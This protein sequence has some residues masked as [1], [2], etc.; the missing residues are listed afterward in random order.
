MKIESIQSELPNWY[1]PQAPGYTKPKSFEGCR[2][3]IHIP[4]GVNPTKELADARVRLQPRYPGATLHLVPEY[5]KSSGPAQSFNVTG[6]DEELLRAYFSSITLPTHVTIDQIISYISKFIPAISVFGSKGMKFKSVI[7]DNVLCFEHCEIDLDLTG[8]TLVT[9]LNKD[10]NNHSNGSG[11]SSYTSLPFIAL[12]GKTFKDQSQDEWAS[13]FN[14]KNARISLEVI[15]SDGR[16]LEVIRQRRPGALRAFLDGNEVTMGTVP[17]T[18]NLI[19]RLTNLTWEVLTN[20]LYI[21]Q[22]EI[23]SVFGT[24]KDRKELFSRLLGLERFLDAQAK[25]S[26]ISLR[27]KRSA[28]LIDTDIDMTD[29]RMQECMGTIAELKISLKNLPQVSEKETSRLTL[30][31]NNVKSKVDAKEKELQELGLSRESLL[32]ETREWTS[33]ISEARTQIKSFQKTL[34]DSKDA[35]ERCHVCGNKIDPKILNRFQNEL[36]T[37]IVSESEQLVKFTNKETNLISKI[38]FIRTKER[39]LSEEINKLKNTRHQLATSIQVRTLQ[40]DEQ[41][42]LL[43][44]VETYQLRIKELEKNKLIHEQAKRFTLEEKQFVDLCVNAVSRNGLPAYLC[45]TV[46][47]QLNQT[48]QHYSEVFADGEIGIQFAASNGDVDVDVRNLHGGKQTKDQSAGEMR[49]AAIVTAFTFR[50]VL[51]QL[52]LLI[53]DEPSEGF[54]PANSLAFAKGLNQVLDRFAHVMV[55]S[56][57]TNL[58][59]ALEPDRRIEIVKEDGVSTASIVSL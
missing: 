59:S 6:S 28:E 10:W 38:T 12:F 5:T 2:V 52:N 36:Q 34:E 7:A 37:A 24:E 20:A 29:A 8:L 19:E 17:A 58:L 42:R 21:G 32:V 16:K 27:I 50:D 4:V 46:T 31:L 13:Q 33:K 57:N 22:S 48:A 25:L 53:I 51:L 40:I 26:K 44:K 49:M 23:G 11:K 18:Q 43:Q 54:D 30:E 39:Q 47:P 15:L 56:H 45:E 14:D 9:G 41:N 1:D 55:I 35:K 3:R